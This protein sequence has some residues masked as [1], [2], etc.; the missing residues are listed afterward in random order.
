[1]HFIV[2]EGL[3]GSGKSTQIKLLKE[4]LKNN[5]YPL[6]YLHFPRT[7]RPVFGDMIARFLRGEMGELDTVDPYMVALLYA[8]D[9]NDAKGLINQ[10]LE[11]EN[12]VLVDRYVCSNIAF[13]C[14]KVPGETEKETLRKWILKTEY[15]YFKIPQPDI[16][17]FLDVPFKFTSKQLSSER[18]GEDR[19]YL[20][21][22]KDIHEA[23][24]DFQRKVREVYH[25]QF[26]IDKNAYIIDC[27]D[28][29]DKILP[30]EIIFEKIIA[31][32]KKHIL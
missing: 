26:A 27:G 24:L 4:Y 3:D 31:L 23:S 19:D 21:G 15:D 30:P 32:L 20:E 12:L 14:A 28:G 17:I 25:Q 5:K 9:R 22:N 8:G 16:N 13:Q 6:K 29:N 18:K 10:W 1:M 11:E 2:I 7:D